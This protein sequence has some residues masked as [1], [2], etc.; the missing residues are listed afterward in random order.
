MRNYFLLLSLVLFSFCYELKAQCYD[1]GSIVISEIYFDTRFGENI[2]TKYHHL[3]EYIELYNSSNVAID[4]QGWIIKDNHTEFTIGP[5]QTN[6]P[7]SLNT[8]IQPGGIKIITFSNFYANDHDSWY[9][10]GN[11]NT[12]LESPMGAVNKFIDLFP[13]AAGHEDDIIL[14]NRMV[15]YNSADKVSLYNPSGRL[16]HEISYNNGYYP[17]ESALDYMGINEFSLDIDITNNYIYNGNGGV[18]NGAIGLIN[19]LDGNGNPTYYDEPVNEQPILF[20]SNLYQTSIYLSDQFAYYFDKPKTILIGQ[21]T[22]F[23]LPYSIPLLDVHPDLLSPPGGGFNY[24]HSI[25]YDIN[26]PT[27]QKLA[28]SRSY[29]DD[30]AKP[31]VSM[32]HNYF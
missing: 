24:V 25:V 23:T 13:Q 17:K 9:H 3:G 6:S 1:K 14:Q 21:A 16:V 11:V 20:Q 32:S 28:E 10:T 22:P 5:I 26:S 15:L 30:F 29:F 2:T 27:S 4:L 8:I 7:Y 12:G 31:R 18:F 19:V